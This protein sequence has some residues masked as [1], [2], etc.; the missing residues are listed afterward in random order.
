MNRL[1]LL[2]LMACTMAHAGAMAAE[3]QSPG[4]LP[5]PLPISPAN[6]ARLH[7][8]PRTVTLEWSKVPGAV[9]YGLETDFYGG[10]HWRSETG[11]NRV[12]RVTNPSFTYE[13]VGNQ[14]GGW[15]VWAIDKD[16]HPGRVSAW[17]VFTFGNQGDPI[18]PPP[19]ATTPDFS[20]WPPWISVPVPQKGNMRALPVLDPKTGEACHWPPTIIKGAS[21]P[22]AIYNPNPDYPEG[23]GK[24]KQNGDVELA[25]DIAEDGLVKRVCILR[26]SRDDLGEQALNTVRT[27]RFE[28]SRMDAMP[29]PCSVSVHV[30][31]TMY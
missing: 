28:P 4:L 20:R 22:K 29:V 27:W 2:T 12:E 24:A 7:G 9:G 21:V 26:A 31:F 23:A 30:S 5:A 18:P 19:P 13:F 8:E 15:R 16:G 6:Q 17:S 10:G 11:P 3:A 1:L 25:V 14:P